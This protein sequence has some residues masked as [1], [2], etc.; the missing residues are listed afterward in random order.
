MT[1]D[2]A[3]KIIISNFHVD[4]SSVS[5]NK[6]KN[7]ILYIF[8]PKPSESS[9]IC[10][11]ARRQH[12]SNN[13]YF[14]FDVCTEL[15]YAKCHDAECSG[16]SH[17][18]NDK[19]TGILA[20]IP[21][22]STTGKRRKVNSCIPYV[23]LKDVLDFKHVPIHIEDT[24]IFD[25]YHTL[26]LC[27]TEAHKDSKRPVGKDWTEI[28]TEEKSIDMSKYNLAVLTGE[29]SKVFVLDVDVKDNGLLY[30]QNLCKNNSYN[31]YENTMCVLTPSGGL[32]LYFTYEDSFN[33]NKCRLKDTE[34]NMI[35]LD[36]RSNNG[37]VI[38]PPSEY[39]AGVYQFLCV[40]SPQKCPD[41]IVDVFSSV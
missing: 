7:T 25:L 15:I 16:S 30:F 17:I 26:N 6:C 41:F 35:G 33:K 18:I 12:K 24:D 3:K 23:E 29:K 31:Y 14:V 38:A 13:I 11:I 37:C 5:R 20:S 28:K 27:I 21:H 9:R 39:A 8:I 19:T 1:P 22:T 10:P 2:Q 34:G 40:K 36:I 4:I 32:H